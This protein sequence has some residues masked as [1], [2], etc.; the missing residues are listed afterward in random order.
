MQDI[1]GQ[2]LEVTGRKSKDGKHDMYDV[3]FSDGNKYTTFEYDLAQKAL[4]L[5]GQ[6]VSARTEIKQNGKWTNFNLEDI[7]PQGQLGPLLTPNGGTPVGLGPPGPQPVVAAAT[8]PPYQTG[9]QPSI[10]FQQQENQIDKAQ[11]I[12]RQNVLGTAHA[13]VGALFQGAGPE[14]L[15]EASEKAL[16]LA[17]ELYVIAWTGGAEQ[18]AQSVPATPE[19]VAAAVPGVQV[20]T[21]SLVKW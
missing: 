6:A 18:P 16:A 8:P 2:V 19:E 14:A 12:V 17:R 3:A 9:V 11:R 15:Q 13:F 5:K 10:P 20:G 1:D 21:E 7:A 4:G